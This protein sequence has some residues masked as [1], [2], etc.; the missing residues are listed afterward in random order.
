MA[1][2]TTQQML[3]EQ[4]VTNEGPSGGVAYALW[5]FLGLVGAHRFYLGQ[6]ATGVIMLVLSIIG[7]GLFIT[8]PWLIVDA[9]LIPDMMRR[10]RDLIRHQLTTQMLAY[11]TINGSHAPASPYVATYQAAPAHWVGPSAP[12]APPPSGPP[13][14]SR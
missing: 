12:A 8:V 9:F 5:F 10:K 7:I 6:A 3:I 11:G 1:L 14:T 13:A 2:D 4:R